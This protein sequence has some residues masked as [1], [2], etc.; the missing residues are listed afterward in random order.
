M[1]A[2]EKVCTRAFARTN[3]AHEDRR[4]PI[5]PVA[6]SRCWKAALP[7]SA[8]PTLSKRWRCGVET[9]D[10]LHITSW[11]AD[12]SSPAVVH[13]LVLTRPT[14]IECPGYEPHT[15]SGREC[16]KTVEA[17]KATQ[18]RT[19]RPVTVQRITPAY[20]NSLAHAGALAFQD[21][22]YHPRSIDHD[23]PNDN[24][25]IKFFRCGSFNVLSLGDVES[26][27]I[28][29]RLRR[30]R[31]LGR[32]NDVMIL[33]HHGADNGFTTKPFLGVST[34]SWPSVRPT[35][36]I[37]T[38]IPASPSATSYMSGG[39]ACSRPRLA[40]LSSCRSGATTVG[41]AS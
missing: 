12:H 20:I 26:L 17:Y 11:D 4:S 23:C 3:L 10:T 18:Q 37:S 29:A 24:S 13:L 31:Y 35:T 2:H 7:T 38:T 36:T 19:N 25:T 9:T 1:G 27:S 6:T 8:S 33:A 41:F 16:S 14:T 39:F 5:L 34:H 21:V 32:E 15:D 30:D 22:F 40:T 28:S